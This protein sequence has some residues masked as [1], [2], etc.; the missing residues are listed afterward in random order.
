MSVS[1]LLII[2]ALLLAAVD[3][4]L[5]FSMRPRWGLMTGVAVVLICIVWLISSSAIHL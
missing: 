3:L 4:V 5:W 1:L 2:L